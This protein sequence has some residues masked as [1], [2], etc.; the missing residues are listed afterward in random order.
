[1]SGIPY[2]RVSLADIDTTENHPPTQPTQNDGKRGEWSRSP[3]VRALVAATL[4]VSLLLGGAFL[5]V[6]RLHSSAADSLDHPV[7][8]VTDD[9]TKAQVVE[10]AKQIV[11]LSG[12][13]TTSAGYLLMSCKD[14]DDPP[15]RGAIYLNFALPADARA[16]TYFP[17]IAATLVAHGWTEGLPPSDHVFGR[18]LSKDAVTAIIY[19]HS[20]DPGV[21]VLRLSGQC[22]DMNDHRND[23]TGWSDITGD[24]RRTG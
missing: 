9:Q 12:L 15:Y 14:R 23:A 3:G 19:R 16:D 8:P 2:F 10:P 17:T 1:M 4:L 18:T 20:D 21:G 7:N 24:F 5:S 13:Q 6:D 11:S 22:R